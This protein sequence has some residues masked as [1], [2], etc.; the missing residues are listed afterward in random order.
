M[1]DIRKIPVRH[2]KN[3]GAAVFIQI[4]SEKAEPFAKP[5]VLT[6]EALQNI[7]HC[8]LVVSSFSY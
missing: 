8:I 4:F 1:Q 7:A 6:L 3:T 2:K 5:D